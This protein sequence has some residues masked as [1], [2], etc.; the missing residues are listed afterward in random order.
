MN[1]HHDLEGIKLVAIDFAK[2]HNCNYNIIL[3]NP[4]SQGKFDPS[5]GSTYE[6]VIDSYFD[7]PRPN[8][9]ILHKTDDLLMEAGN[10]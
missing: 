9:I 6:F 5:E 8:A 10:K 7:K 3:M 2:E 1:I 4:N